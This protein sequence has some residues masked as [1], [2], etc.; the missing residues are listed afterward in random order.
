MLTNIGASLRRWRRRFSRAEWEIGRLRLKRTE[1]PSHSPGLLLIQIDGLSYDQLERAIARRRLPFLSRLL[2]HGG[3][4]LHTFYSGQPATTPAVQGEL[5]YGVKSAVPAFS[6]LDPKADD[7]GVMFDSAWAKRI[8]SNLSSHGEGLLKE[9]SSWSNIYT[10]GADQEE[11]HFCGASIGLSDMW[12]TGKIRNLFLFAF[13]HFPSFLR[14]LALLPLEFVISTYDAIRG[15]VRGQS[16]FR[17]LILIIGRVFICV[18][19]REMITLGAKIDLARGLP[20]IHVNFLGYDEQSH[21]RGPGSRF[22]HWTLLGIDRAIRHL[23]RSARRSEG[24]DYEVWLF[25][26]HGQVA[27]RPFARK[28]PGGLEGLVDRLWPGLPGKERPERKGFR[29]QHRVHH[30]PFLQRM[31]R[32]GPDR[33][34]LTPFE[35]AEFVVACMGPVGHVYFKRPLP[36]EDELALARGLL[37]EGVPGILVRRNDEKVIWMTRDREAVLPDDT[38]LLR[39]PEELLPDIA[40]D[41]ARLARH[42]CAGNLVCLGWQAGGPSYSFADENGAHAGPSPEETRGFL[43]VPPAS[44][45]LISKDIIR[46]GELRKAALAHLGRAPRPTHRRRTSS[47]HPRLRVVTYNVHY[48]KGLDGRFAP[49]RVARVLRELDPDIIAL[50]ELDCGRPRSRG[51]DQLAYFAAELGLHQLFAPS[52]VDGAERYGHGL[53]STHPLRRIRQVR[54]PTGGVPVIEPRDVLYASVEFGGQELAVVST[55]LGL[56]QAERAAQIDRLL[57]HDFLGGIAQDRPA[58]LMG[59]F[60]LAPGGKLYRRL[61]SRWNQVNGHA[62]FRDVQAHA[63]GHVAVKTFPSFLPLRQLDHIF[64]T[65]HFR[66]HRVYSPANLLTRRASDHLPLVAELELHA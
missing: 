50:Q 26:D 53:L 30:M 63:P 6:F 62:V 16:I 13:L 23:H 37:D 42:A 21:R 47:K 27:C 8:E 41:L 19:L 24:R 4:R 9:G 49:D 17:E 60:N 65:P 1:A 14:L 44:S 59:D 35:Q 40:R 34:N 43:L 29:N 56:A 10:G 52:I 22:A 51:D 18:G 32:R 5:Y 58:I 15:M 48:C 55:H 38:S 61:V 66:I 57:D 46:P 54:L 31:L 39:G 36:P 25:S 7:V 12:R 45:H 2:E 3:Y 64:A 11:S 33:S 20:I 28:H